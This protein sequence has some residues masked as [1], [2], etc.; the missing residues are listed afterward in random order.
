MR[1]VFSAVADP[2]R[3]ELVDLLAGGGELPLHE[4]TAR[5]PMGRTAVSKHLALLKESG[6]VVDRRRGRETCY[7]L[8]AAPLR[9]VQDWVSCYERL[10]TDRL[11]RLKDLVEG[12]DA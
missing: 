12:E 4:L 5:L 10:W 8:N 6:L 2:T 1:D 7:Q 9:E 11:G 3:R